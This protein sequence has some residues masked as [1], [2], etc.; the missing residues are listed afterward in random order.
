MLYF[1]EDGREIAVE[2]YSTIN[3]KYF[4][5]E[6]QFTLDISSWANGIPEGDGDNE[7]SGTRPGI[8][9]DGKD[10][11]DGKDGSDGADGANGLVPYIGENG[12]WWIG[13][14]DTGVKARGDDGKDG[15]DGS[16]GA[17][18][19]VLDGGCGAVLGGSAAV[20]FAVAAAGALLVT[21]K[22]R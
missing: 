7:E 9:I 22:R 4:L 6:N 3:E 17:D 13:D 1:S 8:V 19:Q 2:T 10:G 20:I 21:K 5:E 12:N 18:G 14:K 15:S 16:D 11:K